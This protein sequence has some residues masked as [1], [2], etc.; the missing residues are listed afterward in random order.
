[1]RGS[2]T[3]RLI[4]FLIL[5]F[6]VGCNGNEEA[7][8]SEQVDRIRPVNAERIYL[9]DGGELQKFPGRTRPSRSVELAFRVS[10]KIQQLSIDV[11]D[12]VKQGQLIAQLDNR[13]YRVDLQEKKAAYD[14]ADAEL[15]RYRELFEMGS[16][17]ENEY[18]KK[19]AAFLRAKVLRV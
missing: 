14:L 9:A 16:I 1:M 13:D 4:P 17:A 5:V 8:V 18:D 11:G 2:Q 19:N 12:R 7:P 3:N 10:G 6:L 15:K